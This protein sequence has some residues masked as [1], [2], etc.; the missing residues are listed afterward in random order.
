MALIVNGTT[1]YASADLT[2][3]YVMSGAIS[4]TGTFRTGSSV[5]GAERV[6]ASIRNVS[7]NYRGL[8]FR[9]GADGYFKVGSN[10]SGGD[11]YGNSPWLGLAQPNT[12]YRFVVTKDA[13][14]NLTGYLDSLATTYT[15]G[16]TG[17]THTLTKILISA[18]SGNS[19]AHSF[20]DGKVAR[21]AVFGSVLSS[22]DIAVCLST[23]TAPNDCSVSPIEYWTIVGTSANQ[24]GA[25]P[26]TLMAGATID[27]DFVVSQT[28]SSING[29][30][31]ITAG[32]TSIPVVAANFTA[33]PT[34]VTATYDSGTK[35]IAAT[36][37][38]GD[39]DNFDINIADRADAGF[40]PASSAT[41][42]F[43]F[44]YGSES[45]AKTAPVVKKSSE[46]L[47][48]ISSPLFTAKTLAQA[49]L[50]QTGRTVATGDKF[51]HTTY[52]DFV[53]TADTDYTVTNEGTFDLWLWVS[54]GAD[55]GKMFHYFVTVTENG[56]VIEDTT[57][58]AFTF[59][60]VANATPGAVT[61]A[62]SSAIIT[63]VAAETD[64][65][66]V[67]SGGLSYRVSTDGGSTFG[68]WTTSTTNVRLGYVIEARL[69]ASGSHATSVVGTLTVGGVPG[70]L[71][72][73]T[74]AAPV[75]L[76]NSVSVNKLASIT[77]DFN[78]F[79][80]VNV[81]AAT[82][83]LMTPTNCQYAV[84]SGSG[85]GAWLSNAS[86]VRLGYKVKPRIVSSANGNASGSLTL[87]SKVLNL[88]VKAV[89]QVS[90]RSTLVSFSKSFVK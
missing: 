12:T 13:G 68:S 55:A 39:E 57:P 42:T 66:A 44:T 87:D 24:V 18:T 73:T 82:D 29:G 76:F 21:F 37:G 17:N 20:F 16:T 8:N 72:I 33:K 22:A 26:L 45:A 77:Y 9:I 69:A 48:D 49:I 30:S 50:D 23:L 46:T 5:T 7:G 81:P 74:V 80:V 15:R 59:G 6:V 58:T 89:S 14:G 34:A 51:Y 85:Y 83:F 86:N 47:V 53:I 11:T 62:S 90:G 67:A 79:T 28:I 32:Q 52:G 56:A 64:I 78:E 31:P 36:I 40:Y 61:P 19:A 70:T 41:V 60:A 25:N 1:Q 54:S 63:G 3:S 10:T 2:S 65:L 38:A 75:L 88:S 43:T 71:T 4:F 84:D 35:S 27:S